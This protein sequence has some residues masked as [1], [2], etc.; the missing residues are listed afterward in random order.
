MKLQNGRL[1]RSISSS[2]KSSFHLRT[3]NSKR[4]FWDPQALL[5]LHASKN[6]PLL[7]IRPPPHARSLSHKRLAI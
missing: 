5:L 3:K 1:S 7:S 6:P 4:P 2:L